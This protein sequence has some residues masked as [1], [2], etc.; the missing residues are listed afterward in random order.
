MMQMLAME[1]HEEQGTPNRKFAAGH[2][3][4]LLCLLCPRLRVRIGIRVGVR[5]ILE[6]RPSQLLQSLPKN[7]ETA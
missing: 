2:G 7:E 1:G 3:L 4:G 5:L 6:L